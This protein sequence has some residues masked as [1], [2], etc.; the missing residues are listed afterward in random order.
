MR[1][2]CV[3]YEVSKLT[4]LPIRVRH[5]SL[6]DTKSKFD[7]MIPITKVDSLR[8]FLEFK[9]PSKNLD[10][11]LSRAPL[12]AL[13]TSSSQLSVLKSLIHL[14]YL[15]LCNSDITTLPESVCRLQKLQTLK[16]EED[17][18]GLEE[19]H[20]LQLVGKLHIKGLENV[21][22][23][24]DAREANLIGKKDLNRLYLSWGDY[25]NSQV[26]DV[27]A[28]G[29]LEALE[30]HSGLKSFGVKSYGGAHFP[31]WMR[32][33]SILK[34]LVHIILY[35]CKN[36]KKLPPLGKLPCLTTLYVCGMRDLKYI[37]DALYEPATEKAFTSLKKLT[38]CDLP[39]L[40]GVL[41][42]EGVEML[43]E[44]SNLSISCVPKLVL[45]SLPSVEILS[46]HG[47]TEVVLKF[48]SYM[49]CDED[50]ASSPRGIVG[51][52]MYNLKSLYISDFAK[53]KELP[54]E[55]GTLCVLEHLHIQF[56]DEIE[57]FSE[58]L[59]QG[60]SSLRTLTIHYCHGF[61]SLSGELELEDNLDA[62]PTFR[63]NTTSEWKMENQF[64]HR[65]KFESVVDAL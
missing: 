45:P 14:R 8:T 10:V 41:K 34:G 9:P 27:D 32:N 31:L 19:L 1:E 17:G 44:L 40:E 23:E 33:T 16:L 36:C 58:N 59:L 20:N 46:A 29:V 52:T 21:S 30:P 3:A 54:D 56:C 43:P 50:L 4:D 12:R 48:T 51:N 63:E 42:V 57:S 11:L 35:D 7:Y 13:R 60:L 55:L 28:E 61:K 62:K 24:K 39:N 47:G 26:S 18:F 6:S 37:D 22:N 5:I 25:A 49:N 64:C 15:E 38:L 65:P 53:L 2:E